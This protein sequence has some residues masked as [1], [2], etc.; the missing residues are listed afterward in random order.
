AIAPAAVFERFKSFDAP[1]GKA[2]PRQVVFKGVLE[3]LPE[4]WLAGVG[5]S[6]YWN[7]WAVKHGIATRAPKPLGAHNSFFQI[8]TYWGLPGLLTYLLLL[9]ALW[10]CLPKGRSR[11]VLA[12]CLFG[13]TLALL[14][15]LLFSHV[16]FVKDFAA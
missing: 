14:V 8:W 1:P 12:L 3:G 11:D 7:G 6:E 5:T 10:R 16:F 9:Y 2:D 13:L 15:R 4:F